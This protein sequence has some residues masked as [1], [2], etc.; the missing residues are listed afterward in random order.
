MTLA[1][2]V[3][4]LDLTVFAG[5]NGLQRAVKSGYAGD[6]LSDVM[7]RG[8]ENVLWI[9]IQIHP[10]IVAVAVLKDLAGVVISGGR[11]PEPETVQRAEKE[12][13][14]LLGSALGAFELAGRLHGLGL[15]G[16]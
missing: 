10:N 16:A 13:L 15:R 4:R 12:G 5:E 3:A 6:L 11:T 2:L 14:P 1:E 9:T 8:G 7:A